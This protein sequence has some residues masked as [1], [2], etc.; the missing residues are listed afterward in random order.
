M[1]INEFEARTRASLVNAHI[2]EYN[3]VKVA[4]NREWISQ[5]LLR[6]AVDLGKNFEALFE[7]VNYELAKA[8]HR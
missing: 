6:E 4:Q 2:N 3:G 7:N 5:E 1:L 8:Q